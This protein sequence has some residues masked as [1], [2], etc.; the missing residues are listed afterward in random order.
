M[1]KKKT[2]KK[3][4]NGK[5]DIDRPI[6]TKAKR[7]S[8]NEFDVII[9]YYKYTSLLTMIENANFINLFSDLK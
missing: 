5:K 6:R 8:H 2:I 4:K 1:K 7:I 9:F 3:E